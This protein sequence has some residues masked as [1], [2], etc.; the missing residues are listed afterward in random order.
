M[1]FKKKYIGLLILPQLL[2]VQYISNHQ[3]IIEEYYSLGVY[4]LTSKI[5]RST[6]SVFPFSIGDVLY[7]ITLIYFIRLIVK[8]ISMKKI[9]LKKS[10]KIIL[11]YGSIFHFLF[12]FLWGLNYHRTSLHEKLIIDLTYTVEDL[13]EISKKLIIKSNKLHRQIT[14]SDSSS[15]EIPY[16]I[17]KINKI[18]SFGYNNLS[19]LKEYY[20]EI[21][22]NN[23]IVKK[24]LISLPLTYLGFSGYINPFT[25]ESQINSLIPKNSIPHTASHEIA[26]QLGFS[27]ELECNFIAFVNLTNSEDLYFKYNGYSFALRQCLNEL[28]KYD[29]PTYNS[30]LKLLNTGILKDFKNNSEFWKNYSNPIESITKS[31]YDKFLKFNNISEG[32]KSYNQSVSLII[33]YLK[34]T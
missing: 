26:H 8:E 18:A 11:F 19:L 32:I 6:L 17:K 30:L 24:S 34:K 21:N 15:T 16:D 12:Y 14:L 3:E 9:N 23:L 28:Y 33:N 4:Q 5:L 7:I 2:F 20:P 22:T 27:Q 25:N 1:I 13:E 29:K 10:I 31:G